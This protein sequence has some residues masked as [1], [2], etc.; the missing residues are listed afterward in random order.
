MN[1][2]LQQTLK[3]EVDEKADDVLFREDR[4]SSKWKALTTYG[5]WKSMLLYIHGLLLEALRFNIAGIQARA[6]A[7]SVRA[8]QNGPAYVIINAIA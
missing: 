7:R 1:Q 4:E 6:K 3:H 2:R 5:T 8:N